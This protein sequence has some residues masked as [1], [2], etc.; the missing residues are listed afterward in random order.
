MNRLLV[1]TG[2][3]VLLLSTESHSQS[4]ATILPADAGHA[5]AASCVILKR[6]GRMGRT[7]SRLYH[8]GISGKHFRYV[9][10][11][12]PEGFSRR[13]KMTDHDVRKLQAHGAQVLV[14]DTNYTSDDLKEARSDCANATVKTSTQVEAKAS[15]QVEAKASPQVEAKA[16]P[17][18]PAPIA[19]APAA[20]SRPLN[21]KAPA[22]KP[23]ASASST[24]TTTPAAS[25]L[26]PAPKALTKKTPAPKTKISTSSTGTTEAALVDVS[27]TPAGADV[28][29][30]ERLVGQ[31]PATTIILMPGSHKIAVKKDGFVVWRKTLTLPSGRTNLAAE[32]FHKSK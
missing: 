4:A 5:S 21:A 30:D 17:P 6:I 29:V 14:L 22:P 23:D 20:E 19:S 16:S 7:E 31:T 10:G 9:E 1:G 28:Y 11:K 15:L 18:T 12:L 32:L 13:G 25:V 27:S 8:F 24:S 2:F 26:P 3:A